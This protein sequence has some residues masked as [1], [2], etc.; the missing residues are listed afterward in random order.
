MA[1]R[2]AVDA[3]LYSRQSAGIG[4][5]IAELFGA[6]AAR[7]PADTL[8]LV[9]NRGMDVPGVQLISP[10][11]ELNRS[12]DR[13]LYEQLVLPRRLLRERYDVI[14]FPD[15]Q[16][17]ILS[18]LPR[19]VITVHDLVAFRFPETFPPRVG[20]VKRF[21]MRASVE[22]AAHIIVPSQATR[23]DLMETLGV[24]PSRITVVSH[25]VAPKVRHLGNSPH[26]RPYFLAVGTL[27]P[28]KNL[29]RLIHGYA[30]LCRSLR[31]DCPDLVIVGRPGWMYA[32][33][34]RAPHV[35][36]V[37]ERVTFVNYVSEADLLAFYSHAVA[38]CYPSLYEGFGLPMAE[39]MMVGTPVVAS[40]RGA[41]AEIGEEV[42]VEVDP[43]DIE[44]IA[45]GLKAV[46]D[47]PEDMGQR[48]RMGRERVEHLT[49]Q[50]TAE[51]T[52]QV[53]QRVAEIR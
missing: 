31:A 13:L 34:Y 51:A 43:L 30:Q 28:R 35:A 33:I 25:G 41:L 18:R 45:Q 40:N 50:A 11:H 53:Y 37:A 14:H 24:D 2:I 5:Y 46:L 48:V 36:G 16:L 26:P 15:Y 29:E 9:V 3:L 10:R 7:F 22:R 49:W 52:R 38:L 20:G 27:E 6:Y 1:L 32:G 39:A 19:S 8:C 47:N 23:K 4:H 12:R 17:P 42:A 21:L 44:S